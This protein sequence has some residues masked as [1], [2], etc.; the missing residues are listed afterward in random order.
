M[1]ARIV[2][3]M[4]NF[5]ELTRSLPDRHRSALSWFLDQTGTDQPWPKPLPDGT[6][7]ASKA[8][9]I[10]KPEWSR[11]ALSVRQSL[12]SSYPDREPVL[13]PDGTWSH[14]YFQEGKDPSRRDSRYTNRSLMKCLQDLTPVGV[15]CETRLATRRT[16]RV[17][18]L[19][20]VV[21]WEDGY[22][23]LEGFSR[24][25]EVRGKGPGPLIDAFTARE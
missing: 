5:E 14:L 16:Y 1:W 2:K 10:Y 9:G 11:Y 12:K 3:F 25:G 24:S 8:K 4:L 15:F 21:G 6:L 13:R 17:L 20:I 18:G 19:A 22:Y 7:L 23:F